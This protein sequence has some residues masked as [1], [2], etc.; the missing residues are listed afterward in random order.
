MDIIKNDSSCV[1][2]EIYQ[3]NTRL[4]TKKRII[5]L[6]TNHKDIIRLMNKAFNKVIEVRFKNI[7]FEDIITPSTADPF[8]LFYIA[9]GSSASQTF[10]AN[11]SL[12]G[13][14][15]ADEKLIDYGEIDYCNLCNSI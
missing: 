15:V 12:K 14:T 6:Q 9:P 10:S 8:Q 3:Q 5:C 13:I 1:V 7:K 11:L 2:Y 4:P